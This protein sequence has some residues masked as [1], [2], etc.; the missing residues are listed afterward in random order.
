MRQSAVQIGLLRVAK[1]ASTRPITTQA[2][3]QMC[4]ESGAL[5]RTVRLPIHTRIAK[6]YSSFSGLLNKL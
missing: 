2:L 5:Q 1:T 3:C 6:S 4:T